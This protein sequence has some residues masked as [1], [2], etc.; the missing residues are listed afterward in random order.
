MN[1]AERR[2]RALGHKPVTYTDTV[3]LI[4]A[5]VLAIALVALAVR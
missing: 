3:V 2:R 4:L 1:E 5:I